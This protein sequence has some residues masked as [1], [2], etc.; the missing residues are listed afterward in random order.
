MLEEVTELERAEMREF[1]PIIA[2]Q[3]AHMRGLIRDL[4]DAGASRVG[5]HCRYRPSP[6]VASLVECARTTFVSGGGRHA[7][8][9]DAPACL[10]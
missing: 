9:V 1:L 6:A 10:W 3:A 8:F 7:V 2:E 4:L 5:G